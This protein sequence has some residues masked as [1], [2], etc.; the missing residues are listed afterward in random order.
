MKFQRP[1]AILSTQES[2][3]KL[4]TSRVTHL[5]IGAHPDDVEFMAYHGIEECF[6]A[7]EK[8]FGAVICTDGSAPPRSGPLSAMSQEEIR[9]L[10]QREQLA[11]AGVG[12]YGLTIM[13]DYPSSTAKD[14]S[15]KSLDEDLLKILEA[16]RPEVL[17][18]HNPADK[19]S[20]HV[21]VVARVLRVLREM[22]PHKRPRTLLGCEG[23]RNLDWVSDEK[24]EVLDTGGREHLASALSACFDS[25]ISG[26]KRYD[27]AVLGR[28]RANATFLD[29][30]SV[31]ETS[32]AT[33]ALDLT[34]LMN[35]HSL[36]LQDFIDDLV[37]GMKARIHKELEPWM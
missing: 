22:E 14:P 23:W 19:H 28:R 27:L 32:M 2:D 26:G 9:R 10:R 17:Y 13:L 35:D 16:T 6:G 15:D 36:T 21:A 18:T 8:T 11:A 20:T 5:G 30:H 33:F 37:D 34:R 29:S 3:W 31:D 12:R 25:Q 7:K 1:G 4:A 24:K